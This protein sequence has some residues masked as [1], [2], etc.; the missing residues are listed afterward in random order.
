[1]LK[2]HIYA[3]ISGVRTICFYITESGRTPVEDFLD[4]LDG[5]QTKKSPGSYN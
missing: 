4:S 3:N 1:L 5:K 2:V